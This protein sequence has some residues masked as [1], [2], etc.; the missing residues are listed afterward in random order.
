MRIDKE[1]ARLAVGLPLVRHPL[2]D[3]A[4]R[5]SRRAIALKWWTNYGEVDPDTA[6][7]DANRVTGDRW[8]EQAW[9]DWREGWWRG[10][11]SLCRV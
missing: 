2:G 7:Q 4:P 11:R 5:V 9:I 1:D 8:D 10:A 3:T 6:H